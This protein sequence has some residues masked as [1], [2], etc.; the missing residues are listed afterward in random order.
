MCPAGYRPIAIGHGKVFDAD[1]NHLTGE[2]CHGTCLWPK[3]EAVT[4]SLEAVGSKVTS[5]R[6][7]LLL[8]YSM[9]VCSG[10]QVAVQRRATANVPAGGS[11]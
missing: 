9:V 7:A 5:G 2:G 11:S 1:L 4:D 6:F 3:S 10:G 8:M